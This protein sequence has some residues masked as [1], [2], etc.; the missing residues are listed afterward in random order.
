MS[1]PRRN[2]VE[3]D[4]GR[5]AEKKKW[6]QLGGNGDWRPCALREVSGFA[7]IERALDQSH[8][9]SPGASALPF[10]VSV[11][12]TSFSSLSLRFLVYK[13]RPICDGLRLG[14]QLLLPCVTARS[15]VW[16][17][18]GG[19]DSYAW[20]LTS[21]FCHLLKDGVHIHLFS[22]AVSKRDPEFQLSHRE[23]TSIG[24]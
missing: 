14:P 9:T 2:K 7:E 12:L 11:I 10:T 18:R 5:L 3:K 24:S 8:R 4:R 17:G 22:G 6:Q 20:L 15:R 23:H 21:A 16:G 19:G 13:H 1:R